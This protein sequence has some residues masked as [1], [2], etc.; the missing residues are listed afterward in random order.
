LKYHVAIDIGASSGRVVLSYLQ[1]NQLKLEELYRFYNSFVVENNYD[2]WNIN[3][4][5]ESILI[6]LEK[7]KQEGIEYCT[8]G[9][10]TWAIDYC[11]VDKDGQLVSNPVSYRDNRTNNVIQYFEQQFSK[12]R[13]YQRT[14][15]Q[16]QPFNTIFQLFVEEK[17]KINKTEKI[18]LIPDYLN[19]VFTNTLGIES[20]NASTT[21]LVNTTSKDWDLKLLE[22]ID[23]SIEKLPSIVEPGTIR[24]KFL[25][26]KFRNYNLPEALFI[27]V[28]SHDTASAVIGV[29]ALEDE[30]WLFLS[31]GTWSLLGKEIDQKLI[32]NLTYSSNYSNEIGVFNTVRFLKNTIGMWLIQ[33]VLR[34]F[35][36]KYTYEKLT[37]EANK[38]MGFQQFID[39]NHPMFL[40]PDNMFE[41]I[42]FYC[43]ETKQKVP[44][45]IWEVAR[46]IFDNMA[47][48]YAIEIQALVSM[49]P[50]N[51]P[52]DVLYIVGGGGNNQLLNQ[53]TATLT[54][55]KVVSGPTEATAIG[56]AIVQMITLGEIENLT[57][58]RK[59]I[60]ESTE[61][62]EFHPKQLDLNVIEKYKKF[63]KEY[64]RW[65]V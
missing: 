8:I 59:I 47:L 11:L 6:G 28:G 64:E 56:N 24:G 5:I 14:G 15:I 60:R 18:M 52:I 29:P 13:L 22:T 32:S 1:N 57:S 12:E 40:N 48:S 26:E 10:D 53:L 2:V 37:Y 44:K 62:Q 58:A 19:Y 3:Y 51:E 46:C 20:T 33:E 30:N 63:M 43:K 27:N 16:I 35:N 21:Q 25:K 65:K 31:S 4:L 39:I 55:I 38:L 17:E 23:I 34:N 7:V 49:I 54:Q 41:Q 42:Q 9:I 45:T 61:L 36:Y 50:T